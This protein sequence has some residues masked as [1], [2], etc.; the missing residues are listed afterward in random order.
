MYFTY[1]QNVGLKIILNPKIIHG[2]VDIISR[3]S[4][5]A[6]QAG[7]IRLVSNINTGNKKG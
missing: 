1:I 7:N 5:C 2:A 4:A 3:M 6:A